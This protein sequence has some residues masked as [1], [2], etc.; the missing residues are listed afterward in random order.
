MI[1]FDTPENIRK[2]EVFL[3]FQEVSK[4]SVARNGLKSKTVWICQFSPS[5]SSSALHHHN[6]VEFRAKKYFTEQR[7]AD[8]IQ[9]FVAT[10]GIFSGLFFF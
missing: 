7:I 6:T 1:S 3:C 2:R 5:P 9:L 4:R 8:T 10:K